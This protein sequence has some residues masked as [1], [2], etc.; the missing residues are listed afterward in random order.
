MLTII[1][2]ILLIWAL[3]FNPLSYVE[4]G[5]FGFIS[6]FHYEDTACYP[7]AKQTYNYIY[8]LQTIFIVI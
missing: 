4:A 2:T 7:N 1:V 6:S 5:L 8:S 3:P